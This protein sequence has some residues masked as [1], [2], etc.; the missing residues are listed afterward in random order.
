VCE[1]NVVG[2]IGCFIGKAGSFNNGVARGMLFTGAVLWHFG[3]FH[4]V[5]ERHMCAVVAYQNFYWVGLHNLVGGEWK[6]PYV[7]CGVLITA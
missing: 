5:A 1:F 3:V 4:M 6:S 2:L 7:S